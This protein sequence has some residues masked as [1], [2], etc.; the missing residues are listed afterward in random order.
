ML[1]LA[2]VVAW[3][4]LAPAAPPRGA[5][6][7]SR[8]GAAPGGLL[9]WFQG[10]PY[11]SNGGAAR[12]EAAGETPPQ[13]EARERLERLAAELQARQEAARAQL[14]RV[15]KVGPPRQSRCG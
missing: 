7:P 3:Y 4:L 14:A 9:E 15:E 12:D 2:G 1:F 5:G 13:R 10:A 6:P 11:W 8:S